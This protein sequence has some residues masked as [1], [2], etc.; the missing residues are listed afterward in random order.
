MILMIETEIAKGR[1]AVLSFAIFLPFVTDFAVLVKKTF[2][3]SQKILFFL[4]FDVYYN[5]LYK[6]HEIG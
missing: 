1:T 3:N 5:I 6:K 2:L 4:F